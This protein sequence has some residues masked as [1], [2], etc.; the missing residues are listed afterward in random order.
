[1]GASEP[2]RPN[3]RVRYSDLGAPGIALL[4]DP[5]VVHCESQV[6][7][8]TGRMLGRAC[9][10]WCLGRE[11]PEFVRHSEK[12]LGSSKTFSSRVCRRDFWRSVLNM[13]GSLMRRANRLRRT[14]DR[15]PART[16][17]LP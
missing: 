6:H 5:L 12:V 17:R 1:M 10:L 7:R 13:A 11:L 14:W 2:L 15:P 16:E 4:P 3:A 8:L 9:S